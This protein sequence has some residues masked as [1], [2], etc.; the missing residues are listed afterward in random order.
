MSIVKH[1]VYIPMHD[2]TNEAGV[3][4]YAADK[5]YLTVTRAVGSD[6][7]ASEIPGCNYAVY[8]LVR[9]FD[10]EFRVKM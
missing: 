1:S 6:W 3:L 7:I 8:D 4:L 9:C 5:E 2:I 10:A